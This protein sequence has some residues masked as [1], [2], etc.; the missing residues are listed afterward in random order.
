MLLSSVIVSSKYSEFQG[1]I[2][3]KTNK[4]FATALAPLFL[5]GLAV[6]A[7]PQSTT[8]TLDPATPARPND[9]LVDD[10][11]MRVQQVKSL[12]VLTI[13]LPAWL[14]GTRSDYGARNGSIPKSERPVLSTSSPAGD[15]PDYVQRE[16]ME[17]YGR[18]GQFRPAYPAY[19]VTSS[20]TYTTQSAP[21]RSTASAASWYRLTSVPYRGTDG[22]THYR[23]VRSIVAASSTPA[24]PRISAPPARPSIP[25]P[26]VYKLISS[27]G[28]LEE[29]VGKKG[30]N[31]E[32]VG[33]LYLTI[34]DQN[35]LVLKSVRGIAAIRYSDAEN[36]GIL[37]TPGKVR[38]YIGAGKLARELV[39]AALYDPL[40]SEESVQKFLQRREQE[41]VNANAQA[42]R[43]RR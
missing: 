22:R 37:G 36:M 16:L 14:E 40:P 11:A 19:S 2:Q 35:Q 4:T 3:M 7:Q 38:R 18:S 39:L 21:P 13:A 32:V 6:F 12:T 27:I 17:E 28:I 24:Q 15:L 25:V 41:R 1:E 20:I 23:V 42:D 5:F 9:M 34:V 8:N 31:R 33:I 29:D 30:K 43:Q 26:P 10:L